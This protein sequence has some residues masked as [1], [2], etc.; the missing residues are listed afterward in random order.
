[1]DWW[2]WRSAFVV[3][4]LPGLAIALAVRIFV[5]EPPRGRFDITE[6]DGASEHP[7]PFL[8]VFRLLWKSR[9]ARNVII[10]IV[11]AGLAAS[12]NGA[13]LGPYLIRRFHLSY[14][15]LG[16]IL[17]STFMLGSAISTIGGGLLIHWAA[18]RD[19]RWSMWIPAIGAA[20][21]VPLYV[22]AYAQPTWQAMVSLLFLAS[23]VSATYLAPCFA[24][25]HGIVPPGGRA[26]TSVIVQFAL[27]LM[28]GNIGPFLSG[29]AIDFV[30]RARFARHAI[31]SF[32][33]SCPG[34]HAHPGAPAIV[35]TACGS[36]VA[37]AT[38][39]VLICFLSCMIW[40]ALHFLLAARAM[41][42]NGEEQ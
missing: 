36:A 4:G 8:D 19:A 13:F 7:L 2:G 27:S 32:V 33:A 40:P 17:A 23:V 15:Q 34:G 37:D 18:R 12:P 35:D 31:G 41:G 6:R 3:I 42:K 29:L 1:M 28:A 38:Q 5:R 39:I 26:K 22:A 9:C 20:L 11:G 10:A 21:S 14:S 30:A 25:L 24:A 16:V